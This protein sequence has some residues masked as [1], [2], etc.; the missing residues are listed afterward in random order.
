LMCSPLNPKRRF[1]WK[2]RL[3]VAAG[4]LVESFDSGHNMKSRP[5]ETLLDRK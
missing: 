3:W 5:H 2:C 1:Y 4:E